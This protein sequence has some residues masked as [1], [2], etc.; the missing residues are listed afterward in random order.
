MGTAQTLIWPYTCVCLPPKS[1]AFRARVFSFVGT[2]SV[3]LYNPQT[4]STRLSGR[5]NLQLIQLMEPFLILFLSCSTSGAQLWLYP[6]HCI[7][8]AH[9]T[10]LRRQPQRIWVCPNEDWTWRW[11]GCLDHRD[12]RGTR[13]ARKPVETLAGD[14][15]LL[16]LFSSLL[17]AGTQKASLVG[18]SLLYFL[19][20]QAL[21]GL[22]LLVSSSIAQL[23]ASV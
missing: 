22:P 14:M 2:F 1:T 8:I 3:L 6:H 17:A 13:C 21:K 5:F 7:W 19:A 10:L 20:Y 11:R 4:E 12:L 9:W 16:G 18:P 15:A 23:W